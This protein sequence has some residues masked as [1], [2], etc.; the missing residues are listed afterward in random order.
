MY[1][2]WQQWKVFTAIVCFLLLAPSAFA[3]ISRDY[4][5]EVSATTQESP[6]QITLNWLNTSDG[7]Q[8]QVWRKLKHQT[9]W[10]SLAILSQN[11]TSYADSNVAVGNAYEYAVTK[12]PQPTYARAGYI[13][14][15]IKAPLVDARGKVLLVVEDTY[16][17]DL[18]SELARLQQD[19]VGD[20]WTVIRRDVS[21]NNSP[22]YVRWLIQLEYQ[23][24]PSIRSVFLFGRIPV[25]YSGNYNADDH[26][27]HT[28]AW[29]ADTFYGDVD[30]TWT[31][32]TVNNTSATRVANHNTPGDGKLDQSIIPSDL[33]LEVGRVDLANMP[34]FLPK[35]EKDLLRQYL[36][37][38]NN[39]RH[40]R[41][42]AVR[43]GILFDGFGESGGEAY[44]ASGWRNFAPFFGSANIQE[45][46]QNQ[47]FSTTTAQS[48]LWTY[49][50]S[51]GGH[52]YDNC[53]WVGVTSDFASNDIRTI[54][55]MFFGSYFGDWDVS[56]NF[57]RA[58]LATTT[59]TLTSAWGGRPHW[60]FHHMAQGE[61]IGYSTRLTQNNNGLYVPAQFSR[62]VHVALMGDPTL[63]MHIVLPASD[64]AAVINNGG[65]TLNWNASPDS[66]LV[67]YHVYRATSATGP[68]TRLT[69]SSPLTVR[70]IIDSPATGTYTY[71]V[72]A[73]KLETSS[74]G[75]YYNASQ[76]I[77]VS[78]SVSQSI[79][80]TPINISNAQ[81]VSNQVA[82]RCNG[83]AGQTF[84][85]ERCENLAQW[86]SILTN[87]L[88]ASG[89]YD[90]SETLQGAGRRFYRT[91][92][93][94]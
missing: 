53:Y 80:N 65:V 3:L 37:K 66:N 12:Y 93:L 49:V 61:T 21:R 10:T 33:E 75:S 70:T 40:G 2:W 62:Q 77:F 85:I 90:F 5:I 7:L 82:F 59:Y 47:F 30:G 63:R 43:R 42:T 9:S 48:Y 50:G 16:A 76:G 13:Y 71:T 51:G 15:G 67:G 88:S 69:G 84:A 27:D 20:G 8:F 44:A 6:A 32:S 79:P 94:P 23:A 86:T 56:N 54:F 38:N 36:N 31:D 11:T 58:P 28:G 22:A 46:G 73:I 29:A 81:R 60:Y 91:K 18:A 87:T 89:Y 17:N 24:D 83:Q 41:I 14:A 1:S 74:S 4:A 19:L 72:R 55:T 25:P 34:A 52:Q 57:L 68:F 35:T 45:I 78:A 26:T 64:L 39:F 92:T